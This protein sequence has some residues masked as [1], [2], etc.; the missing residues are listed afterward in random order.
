M[1]AETST[2]ATLLGCGANMGTAALARD[3]PAATVGQSSGMT[4]A[5]LKA[6]SVGSLSG[7]A[8]I[9]I[10]KCG[11]W[12]DDNNLWAVFG[13]SAP[14]TSPYTATQL[15]QSALITYRSIWGR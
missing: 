7:F 11:A 15:F 2:V 8:P 1:A 9:D 5:N 6:I 14:V 12:L 4:T 3:W 10:V 13:E